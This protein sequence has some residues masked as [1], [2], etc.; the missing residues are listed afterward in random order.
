M[1]KPV[2]LFKGMLISTASATMSSIS[3][4]PWSL[5]L[6]VTYSRSGRIVRLAV[7]MNDTLD[8]EWD[9]HS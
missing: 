3:L 1:Q 9:K 7:E 5:Y 2:E 8:M 4:S 6:D